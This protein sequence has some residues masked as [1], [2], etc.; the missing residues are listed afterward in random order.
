MSDRV[1]RLF[2]PAALL[3]CGAL[4]VYVAVY[5]PGYFSSTSYLAGLIFLQVLIAALWNYRQRFLPLLV[6]AFLWAGMPLPWHEAW[7]SGRWFVLAAGGLARLY[8]E[9]VA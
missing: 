2:M 6:V 1:Q 9:C 8:R 7:T 5:L 4:A 3:G